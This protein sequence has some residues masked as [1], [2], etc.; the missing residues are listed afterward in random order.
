MAHEAVV[1]VIDDDPGVRRSLKALGRSYRLAVETYPSAQAFLSAYD[2]ERPGCVLLDV[3]LAGRSGLD[4]QDEL[5]RHGSALPII[6][7]T[8]HGDLATSL[9]AFRAGAVDF[10]EK[11]VPPRT[12]VRRLREALT[13]GRERR[14]AASEQREVGQRFARLTPRERQVA[15]QLVAG[16]TSKQIAQSLGIS[17]RTVEGHRHRVLEKMAV[18]SVVQ[19]ASPLGRLLAANEPL[20]ST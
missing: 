4:L 9:R 13:I 3:R 8:G 12:L 20:R 11:P 16:M 17:I 10:L 6:V 2:P 14:Q 7:M 5:R 15:R 18:R 1:F 19:L